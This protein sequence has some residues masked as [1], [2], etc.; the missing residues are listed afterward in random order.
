MPAAGSAG[1]QQQLL[2]DLMATGVDGIAVSPVDPPNQ[3]DVLNRIAEKALLITP[4]QR[5]PG[6]QARRLHRHR[7]RRG[8]R[9]GRQADQ[10]SPAQRRQDHAVRREDRRRRT[11]RSGCRASSR[12]ST[13]SKVTIIDVRTDDA[14]PRARPEERRRHAGQI[15]GRRLPRRPLELQRPRDPQ[16]GEGRRQDRHGEDRLLR[17]GGRRAR[18]HRVGRRLRHRRP[19]ALR[20]RQAGHRA[21]GA[22]P[23]RR[24]AGAGRRASRS[25]RRSA[26]RRTPWPR[27]RPA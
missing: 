26:S 17:R 22:A 7:Q 2:D 1:E 24:Q 4:G 5:R 10:G 9:R 19:A 6:E 11:P 23:A 27:S 12:S 25:C 3:T 21:H 8:R 13:G 20:V 16:R 14:D 18:G 15:P